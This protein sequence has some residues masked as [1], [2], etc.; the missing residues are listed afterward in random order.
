MADG[1]IN[2]F[3]S[4]NPQDFA[5]VPS[6][7]GAIDIHRAWDAMEKRKLAMPFMNQA[8]ERQQQV[9]EA[10]R[11]KQTEFMS[12]EAQNARKQK[13]LWEAEEAHGNIEMNPAKVR[14]EIAEAEAKA[15][16]AG[17]EAEAKLGKMT[18]EWKNLNGSMYQNL[19]TDASEIGHT[20][21]TNKSMTP[22]QKAF[23]YQQAISTVQQRY[24]DLPLPKQL[25]TWGPETELTASSLRAA[26]LNSAANQHARDL[27]TQQDTAADKRNREDN[28]TQTGIAATR[29]ASEER[30]HTEQ[31]GTREQQAQ[32]RWQNGLTAERKNAAEIASQF[33][34]GDFNDPNTVPNRIKA[35]ME[36]AEKDY[37]RTNPPPEQKSTSPSTDRV[38]VKNKDGK[39]GTIPKSDLA[40]ALKQGF[41][42]VK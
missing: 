4:F 5:G 29:L 40:A 31:F 41:S 18:A 42:E 9:L 16:Y 22:Q 19:L 20:I 21:A 12:P 28:A 33:R 13:M 24:P 36:Q 37:R 7:G 2:P 26:R 15:K 39:I 17:P 8:K 30:R 34:P 1:F 10:E 38:R 11:A 6:M 14:K 3:E 32:Q 25:Q 27:Q 23:A 35:A